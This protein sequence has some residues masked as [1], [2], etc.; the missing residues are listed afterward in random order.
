M[1]HKTRNQGWSYYSRAIVD[2]KKNP[3]A[4]SLKKVRMVHHEWRNWARRACN[5]YTGKRYRICTGRVATYEGAVRVKWCILVFGLQKWSRFSQ[6]EF[7]LLTNGKKL[8]LFLSYQ[9]EQD[10]SMAISFHSLRLIITLL[11]WYQPARLS[12]GRSTLSKLSIKLL[13]SKRM[14]TFK[15]QAL[16]RAFCDVEGLVQ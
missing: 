6:N 8:L 4:T 11:Y 1:S 7:N 5:C 15:F 13:Y 14:H 2:R 3:L 16:K 12:C 9:H 10:S